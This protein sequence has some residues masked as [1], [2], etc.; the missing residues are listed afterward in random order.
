MR[1]VSA[2][3]RTT[4]QAQASTST[5]RCCLQTS[6][7]SSASC[8]MG[9]D[10]EHIGVKYE[11]DP[12]SFEI[13]ASQ[14]P[15]VLQLRPLPLDGVAGKG[16]SFPVA[17]DDLLIALFRGL[18]GGI[19]GCLLARGDIAVYCSHLQRDANNLTYALLRQT[20]VLL[21]WMKRKSRTLRYLTLRARRGSCSSP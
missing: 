7:R 9:V 6:R 3:T 19:A 11:Q 8:R 13:W 12:R 20:N 10:F 4:L 5:S 16:A 17:E 1:W 14:D 21:R 18:L 2:F 15:Y